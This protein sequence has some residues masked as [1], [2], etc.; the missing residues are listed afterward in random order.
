[1]RRFKTPTLF[2]QEIGEISCYRGREEKGKTTKIGL[3]YEKP[4]A[5]RKT[6]P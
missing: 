6:E 2:T 4:Q 3:I 5:K 1:V